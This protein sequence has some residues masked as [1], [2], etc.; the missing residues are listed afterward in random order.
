MASLGRRICVLPKLL[1][2][3]VTCKRYT[4]RILGA[5]WVAASRGYTNGVP[6]SD[7]VRVGCAS[8][9][10]GDSAVA[11]TRSLHF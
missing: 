5:S 2:Y 9:F 10:W 3:N 8:G 6:S 11:G 4:E 7:N 1:R